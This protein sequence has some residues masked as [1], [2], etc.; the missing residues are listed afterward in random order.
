MIR[1]LAQELAFARHIPPRQIAARLALRVR[2]RVDDTIKPDLSPGTLSVADPAPLPIM[3]PRK[4]GMRREGSGWQYEALG[5]EERF[6]EIIDWDR[7][8]PDGLDQLW[9]MTL[10]YMEYAEALA[11]TILQLADGRTQAAAL[12]ESG[13]Q[14]VTEHFSRRSLSEKYLSFL[15]QVVAPDTQR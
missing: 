1:R 10:H 12:G 15:E 11:A 9:R 6:G 4:P 8:G 3:P 5:H 13:R 2:R 14:F 7:P